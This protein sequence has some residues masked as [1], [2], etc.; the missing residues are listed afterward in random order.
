MHVG[1]RIRDRR[2]ELGLS[3]ERVAELMG[4]SPATIYRYES[5]AIMNM[6]I[7]KLEPIAK[8][9]NVHPGYLMGWTDEQGETLKP[10]ELWPNI[11]DRKGQ[12]SLADATHLSE[13][14]SI[15]LSELVENG[16]VDAKSKETF[17]K[18]Q[19][20]VSFSPLTRAAYRISRAYEKATP[21]VQRTVEVAL[22][23]FINDIDDNI[24]PVHFSPIRY[25]GQAASAG[26]GVFLD[27]ESM[28]TI[29]VQSNVLPKGE[30]FAVPVAGDSMEPRYHDGDILMI[31][32][33]PVNVGEIGVFTVD[34]QGYVKQLGRGVLHSLNHHYDDI[35]LTEDIICNG[36]VVGTLDSEEMMEE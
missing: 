27:D 25:S 10:E 8:V 23:P 35:P 24:I 15:S 6:G 34:G 11:N 26:T 18:M 17:D 3:A 22:E 20:A 7:D 36:K 32:K 29:M 9:L 28:T 19:N 16:F 1:D 21:P 30:C 2:K 4:V 13:T 12:I 31:S 5:S 33:V 14:Y